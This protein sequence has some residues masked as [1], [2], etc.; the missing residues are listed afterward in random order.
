MIG[1]C[2]KSML[3]YLPIGIPVIPGFR[4]LYVGKLD[5]DCAFVCGSFQFFM[6]TVQRKNLTVFNSELLKT[7]KILFKK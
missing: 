7:V 2:F 3:A 5:D 1:R 4:C 6:R